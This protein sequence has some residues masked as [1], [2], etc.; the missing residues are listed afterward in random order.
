MLK[1]TSLVVVIGYYD[2]MVAV[3]QI[4][5]RTYQTIP[6]LITAA[7]WYLF[8][9]SILTLIQSRIEKRF[10]RGTAQGVSDQPGWAARMF[11]FRFGRKES[12]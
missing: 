10:S 5:A 6:L 1:T 11:G 2:L 7:L 9:T 3:Q 12:P 8:C 4:Y